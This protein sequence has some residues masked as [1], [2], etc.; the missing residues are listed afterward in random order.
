MKT[1]IVTSADE[2]YARYAQ[3]FL[4][5]IL[6]Q[7]PDAEIAMLDL[8]LGKCRRLFESRAKIIAPDWD[9][10][11]QS[12]QHLKS[13]F[14]RMF[15]PKYFPEYEMILHIDSDVIVQDASAIDDYINAAKDGS[16]ALSLE[17]HPS[18]RKFPKLAYN[19]GIFCIKS[20]SPVWR[21]W[22]EEAHSGKHNI[23]MVD[24]ESINALIRSNR[25]KVTVMSPL[26][27]WVCH[28]ATPQWNG[29]CFVNSMGEKLKLIHFTLNSKV[30]MERFNRFITSASARVASNRP[31]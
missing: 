26:H 7:R 29:T 21:L 20:S 24:Q 9:L 22:Q 19:A 11:P 3:I 8:G 1:I 31:G 4:N 12:K 13:I 5:S 6:S 28:K 16:I 2:S 23:N 10:A 14:S 30:Y 17:D 27:N 25:A 18:Y 15:L